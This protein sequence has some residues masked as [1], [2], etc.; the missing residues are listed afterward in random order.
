MRLLAVGD[1]HGCLAAF[2]DLLNWVLPT[3]DDV[4]V[5]LGDFV[6]RGPNTRGVLDRLIDLRGRLNLICLRGNHEQMMVEAR[7]G[8]RSEQKMWLGVGGIQALQSYGVA[9][10]LADVPREPLELPPKRPGRLLRDRPLYL[11]ARDGAVRMRH[12]RPAGLR[13]ALGVLPG[14]DAAPLRQAGG[15]RAL[16]AEV[17]R[18]EGR[19]GGGLHRHLRPRR[20]LADVPGCQQWPLLADGHDRPTT[21]GT[22]GLPKKIKY[23]SSPHRL[24]VE[25]RVLDDTQV[26]AE[27]VRDGGDLDVAT[28]VLHVAHELRARPSR[29]FNSAATSAVPQ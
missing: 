2:D 28:H 14:R 19:P 25:V 9:A 3:P 27:W 24:R 15:V 6:D 23:T 4:I 16:L 29:R 18:A 8:G 10:T 21:G 22:G 12:G 5:A 1:I 20:R 11:R 13:L 7:D 17:G 26:I